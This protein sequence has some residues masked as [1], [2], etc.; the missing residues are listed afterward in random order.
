MSAS[1]ARQNGRLR[2]AP[3]CSGRERRPSPCRNRSRHGPPPPH[4]DL[5]YPS[6]AVYSREETVTD[7]NVT[8]SRIRLES[9][10]NRISR[11]PL[12]AISLLI[13]LAIAVLWSASLVDDQ[14]GV[15]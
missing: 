4:T 2:R 14:I 12:V 13:G 9:N 3:Q 15:N 6:Y 11:G 10:A 5:S 1:G 8:P 7:I